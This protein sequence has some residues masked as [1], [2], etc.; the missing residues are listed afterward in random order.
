MEPASRGN[1]HSDDQHEITSST[2]RGRGFVAMTPSMGSAMPGYRGDEIN[3]SLSPS[4]GR[5]RPRPT[6][7]VVG[8][9]LLRSTR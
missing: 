5:I 2:V 7:A 9:V 6:E 4:L 3:P 8:L 1:E